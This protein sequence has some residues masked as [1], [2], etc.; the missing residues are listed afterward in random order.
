MKKFLIFLFGV[1]V[2][3]VGLDYLAGKAVDSYVL[4]H[5]LP[6][7]SYSIDYTL[8]DLNIILPDFQTDTIMAV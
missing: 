1:I 2:L 7:D 3:V 6:G 5:R 8:K 4:S